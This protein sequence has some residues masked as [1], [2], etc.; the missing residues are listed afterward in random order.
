MHIRDISVDILVDISWHLIFVTSSLGDTIVD[1]RAYE[2]SHPWIS[3]R[4][5]LARATPQLW[6]L[7]GQAAARCEQVARAVLPPAAAATAFVTAS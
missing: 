7:L 3:F 6:S 1:E 5:G 4:P 2:R